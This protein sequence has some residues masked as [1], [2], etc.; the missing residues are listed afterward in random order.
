MNIGK[1]LSSGVENL[2]KKAT[3]RLH[4]HAA[5]PKASAGS[6]GKSGGSMQVESSLDERLPRTT[7]RRTN[8]AVLRV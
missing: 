1:F 6:L 5:I 2:D 8:A 7:Q 3:L 4:V